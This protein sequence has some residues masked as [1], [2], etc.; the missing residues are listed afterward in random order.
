LDDRAVPELVTGN[1]YL[2]LPAEPMYMQSLVPTLEG[3]LF[4]NCTHIP[5]IRSRNDTSVTLEQYQLGLSIARQIIPAIS[6]KDIIRSF[7]GTASRHTRELE[8]HI[9]EPHR[10]NPRF[11]TVKLRPP[12][13]LA[14]PAIAKHG[15]PQLL[16][17]AGLEL[18]MKRDFKP[19]RKGIPI[20]RDLP[21]E[22]KEELIAKDPNYGHVV[23]RCKTVTEGEMIEAI[24]RG[25]RTVQDIKFMT[26][27]G[28]GRCQGGFCG[29]RV[30]Q[31][32]ARELNIPVTQ[33][34]EREAPC[35]LYENKD[36]VIKKS[37]HLRG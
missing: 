23:C 28:M 30:I 35:L 16:G 9:I 20:F 10:V 8:D 24:R 15:V 4:C 14:M 31:I 34:L 3:N 26:K 25:A 11:F 29:S 21:N 33:V 17:D 7:C 19:D 37:K 6:E 18:T 12:G 2:A 1:N 5:Q 27:A 22:K 36:L 32:L 13:F